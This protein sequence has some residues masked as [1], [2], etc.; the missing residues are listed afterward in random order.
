MA[1]PEL[2]WFADLGLRWHAVP[3]DWTWIV[4]PIS[5]GATSLFHH[6]Y[7]EADQRPNFY[8]DEPAHRLA[9]TGRAQVGPAEGD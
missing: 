8:L 7:Y 4:P 9:L 1:H 5:S 3:A 2:E 6:Y